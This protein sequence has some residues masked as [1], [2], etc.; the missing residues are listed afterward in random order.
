MWFTLV[1]VQEYSHKGNM[2]C[3]GVVPGTVEFNFEGES[4]FQSQAY[5]LRY[6][7]PGTF[8]NP[9]VIFKGDMRSDRSERVKMNVL[10]LGRR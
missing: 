5:S 9:E 10:I 4:T 2:C 6:D 3:Y 8:L 1:N 7:W